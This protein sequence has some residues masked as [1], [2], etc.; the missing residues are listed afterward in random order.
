MPR[1]ED[2]SFE[3][4]ELARYLSEHYVAIEVDREVRPDVDEAH[5]RAVQMLTGGGWPMTVWLTPNRQPFYG[6]TRISIE[7]PVPSAT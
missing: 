3:N 1:D 4:E 7:L 2:E 5:M 6:G